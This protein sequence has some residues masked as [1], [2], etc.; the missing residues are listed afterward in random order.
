MGARRKLRTH[1]RRQRWANKDYKKSNLENEWKKP[2]A[3]S[4]MPKALPLRR[5]IDCRIWT[6]GHTVGDIPGVRFTVVKVSGVSLL[7]LFKEKKE[8]PRL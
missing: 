6:K 4:S 3:G 7:A 5:C 1:R 8:K 2:F